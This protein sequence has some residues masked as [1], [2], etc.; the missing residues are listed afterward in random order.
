MTLYKT[1]ADLNGGALVEMTAD[2][3]ALFLGSQ[4]ASTAE[5]PRLDILSQIIKLEATFTPRRQREAYSDPTFKNELDAQIAT[6]RSQ[7]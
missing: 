1:V 7:L 5:Q 2:E 4:T 6:L 3:E